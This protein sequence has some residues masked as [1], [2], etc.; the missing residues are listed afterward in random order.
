M[1]LDVGQPA[2]DFCLPDEN[3][4]EHC[5]H[6]YR[7]RVVVLYFYPKDNTPGCT[8]EAV[9]FRD[10]YNRFAAA[11]VVIL[12]VSP[13]PPARHQRFKAKYNLPFPLLSDP[14]RTVLRAYDAWGP[15]R[16]F[17]K[18]KEGVLRKTYI[19]DPEGRIA[20]IFPKVKP[21]GHADEVWATLQ[22]L[23]LVPSE[24][25]GSESA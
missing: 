24:E 13:D 1:P 15:K 2:P 7:G 3:G 21:K 20:H 18:T 23:G 16:M 6:D 9:G 4:Q 17:G 19:I 5:L 8:T 11:N 14:E 22:R 10:Q 12:G 25:P